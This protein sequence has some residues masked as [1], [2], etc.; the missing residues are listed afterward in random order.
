MIV[1]TQCINLPKNYNNNNGFII[2]VLV[3]VVGLFAFRSIAGIAAAARVPAAQ[4][5][6]PDVTLSLSQRHGGTQLCA[7][8]YG[9]LTTHPA[10][11]QKKKLLRLLFLL[12]CCCYYKNTPNGPFWLP[13]TWWRSR[14]RKRA[15]NAGSWSTTTRETTF[16]CY[17]FVKRCR[18]FSLSLPLSLPI[19]SI[20]SPSSDT[21]LPYRNNCIKDKKKTRTIPILKS[22]PPSPQLSTPP[23]LLLLSVSLCLS[24]PACV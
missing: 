4:H 5:G 23:L 22:A 1:L 21:C 24:L 16:F 11:N 13:T 10:L 18:C 20:Y 14:R 15:D 7:P 17:V 19:L 3:V 6:L 2:V 9:K 8:L 12:F